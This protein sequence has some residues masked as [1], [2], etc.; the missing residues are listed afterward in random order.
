MSKKLGFTFI[1]LIVFIVVIG[2]VAAV[3]L[4]SF[5]TVF[6]GVGRAGYQTSATGYA[7]KCLEWVLGQRYLTGFSNI[8]CG[9]T[10]PTFCNVPSDYTVTTTVNCTA[11]YYGDA[12]NYKTITTTISGDL[13]GATLSAVVANY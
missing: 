3:I 4:T 1:E 12:N 5:N 2:I 13:G 8:S 6:R 11:N 9:N 7:V 10:V